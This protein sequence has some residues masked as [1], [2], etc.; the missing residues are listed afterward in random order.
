MKKALLLLL[1]AA[2]VLTFCFPVLAEN[3]E[4][5][6]QADLFGLWETDGESRKWIA[7]AVPFSEGV[8]ITSTAMLPESPEQLVVSDGADSWEAKAVLPDKTGMIALVFYDREDQTEGSGA[9]QLLPR[10]MRVPAASCTVRYADGTGRL[11]NCGVLDAENVRL[12]GRNLILL[13]LTEPVRPGS[14]LLTGDGFI[15][16]EMV[17]SGELAHELAFLL[18]FSE[19][20]THHVR[21]QFFC[22][23]ERNL[24]ISVRVAVE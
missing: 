7:A 22:F 8:V 3:A 13:T 24:H 1:A 12:E 20:G 21:E 5:T 4:E 10:G 9:W 11:K 2:L 14:A 16:E 17:Q 19:L 6:K 15:T 18:P 23:N